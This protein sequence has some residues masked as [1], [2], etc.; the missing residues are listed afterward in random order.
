MTKRIILIVAVLGAIAAIAIVVVRNRPEDEKSEDI[1]RVERGDLVESAS[2]SGTVH[3]EAQ[4][5]V[6]SRASGAVLEVAVNTGDRVEAGA[7]LVRLDPT[8]EERRLAEARAAA[9]AATARVAQARAAIGVAR[10]ESEEATARAEVRQSA[11]DAGLVSREEVRQTSSAARSAAA[12][13]ALRQADIQAASADLERARLAIRDAEQR[14]TETELR[15]PVSGTVLQLAVQRGSI[16]A[17]GITNIGGGTSLLTLAD[18]SHL[19]VSVDLDEAQIGKVQVGMEAEIRVDAYPDRTFQ[20]RVAHIAPLG[21]ELQN[22]VTFAVEV[23]AVD[24]HA[25]LLRPGMSADVD[26]VIERH[27]GVLL[28]PVLAVRSEARERYVLVRRAGAEEPERRPVQTGVTDGND[29]VVLDGLREGEEVILSG[30][31]PEEA[32]RRGIFGGRRR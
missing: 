27:A 12:T 7:L 18:L 24:E 14:L 10:N 2:A 19:L 16:I 5:E 29:I 25:D 23:A 31:E 9:A 28:V 3:A 20:G 32:E 1:A 4:V 8:E 6:K 11:L 22:I 17:S 26:I 30:D 13:V 15:A 21:V